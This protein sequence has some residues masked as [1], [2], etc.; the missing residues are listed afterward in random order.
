[1]ASYIL[2]QEHICNL[3]SKTGLLKKSTRVTSANKYMFVNSI[4]KFKHVQTPSSQ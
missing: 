2:M 4:I 3:D 1:M